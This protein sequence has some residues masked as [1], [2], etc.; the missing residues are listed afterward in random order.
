MAG[1]EFHDDNAPAVLWRAHPV[2]MADLCHDVRGT[3]GPI[4]TG[5][6]SRSGA[7]GVR[8]GEDVVL[9]RT[10]EIPVAAVDALP[11]LVHE[12][13]GITRGVNGVR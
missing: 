3:A 12:Q 6:T 13:F 5:Q 10:W 1:T 4:R 7:I 11:P 2:G 9:D 8:S